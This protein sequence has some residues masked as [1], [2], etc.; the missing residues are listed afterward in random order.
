M[1]IKLDKISVVPIRK[2][3]QNETT[4]FTTWLSLNE[5]L[6]LLGME[7]GLNLRLIKREAKVVNSELLIRS[8]GIR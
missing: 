3:F 1:K 7:I 4:D 5:N 6:E 8:Q 2:V